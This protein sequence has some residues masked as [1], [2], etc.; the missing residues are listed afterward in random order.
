V[1]FQVGKFYETYHMDADVLV[2]ELDLVYM[3]GQIAHAGFPE[4]AYGRFSDALVAKGYRWV[5]AGW[6]SCND[7]ELNLY[8]SCPRVAR[9]EQTETPEMLKERNAATTKGVKKDK[10]KLHV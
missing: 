9:V 3:K 2:K 5:C 7:K 4:I 1:C 10:A 8:C 6:L